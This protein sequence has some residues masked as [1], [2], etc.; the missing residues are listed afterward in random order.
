MARATSFPAKTGVKGQ[1]TKT[2]K[3]LEGTGWV[4]A[5]KTRLS[6]TGQLYCTQ[7]SSPPLSLLCPVL[8]EKEGTLLGTLLGTGLLPGKLPRCPPFAP[9]LA[10]KH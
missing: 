1:T 8:P 6:G 10:L 4:D 3:A 5:S 7:L 2:Q 9:V